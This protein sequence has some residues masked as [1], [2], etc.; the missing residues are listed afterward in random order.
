MG[1]SAVLNN[2]LKGFYKIDKKLEKYG[3]KLTF[4]SINEN[5][6]KLLSENIKIVGVKRYRYPFV[7]V[8]YEIQSLLF[9]PKEK[10]NAVH[11]HIL[12]EIFPWIIK[13]PTFFTLHGIFWEEKKYIN[14]KFLS[15]YSNLVNT[16]RLTFY[17]SHI[18]ALV[19]ISPYVIEEL[20]AMGFD[21][22]KAVVIENPVSDEFFE[23]EKEQDDMILYPAALKAIKNQL[24]FLKAFASVKNEL[25]GYKLVFAGSGDSGYYATL[26][27]FAEKHGL[28]AAF[29]GKVPYKEMVRLYSRAS[30]VAL[31]SFQETLPMAAL[32]SLASGTPVLAS[33]VGGLPYV[34]EDNING[35]LVNPFNHREIAEKIIALTDKSL[36]EKLA[37]NAKRTA[38]KYRS[39][40]VAKKLLELYL[41]RVNM[42]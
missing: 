27:H 17:S 24:G 3:I 26:R 6:D 22:K 29:L 2:T 21:I 7:T 41:T 14:N 36:R 28:N 20:E 25:K 13:F 12:Y 23:I 4:M 10:F 33:R 30:F 40:V 38:E 31:T 32:E 15:E 9:S 18:A 35:L 8:T 34:I 11:S 42:Y 1:P 16:L 19:A 5:V 39:D 37:A